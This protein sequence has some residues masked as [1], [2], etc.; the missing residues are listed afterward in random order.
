MYTVKQVREYLGTNSKEL[1]L[2]YQDGVLNTQGLECLT[3]EELLQLKEV[4][5]AKWKEKMEGDN[6]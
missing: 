1:L 3:K 6:S 2:T 4:V 5:V